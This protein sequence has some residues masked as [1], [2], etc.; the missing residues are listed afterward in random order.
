MWVWWFSLHANLSNHDISFTQPNNL[1]L[2]LQP[3]QEADA[4]YSTPHTTPGLASKPLDERS[5]LDPA[6]S[7]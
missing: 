3:L 6:Q 7:T 4:P 2:K 5:T 1:Y